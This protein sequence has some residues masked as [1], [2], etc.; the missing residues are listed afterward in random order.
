MLLD[1]WHQ[2]DGSV[3]VT[4]EIEAKDPQGLSDENMARVALHQNR[5][6]WQ[7]G[8]TG[9]ASYTVCAAKSRIPK[10]GWKVERNSSGITRVYFTEEAWAFQVAFLLPPVLACKC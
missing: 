9:R 10:S 2:K 3:L 1:T 4:I 7:K 8:H 5:L 6:Q